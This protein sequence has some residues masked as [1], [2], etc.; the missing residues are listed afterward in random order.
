MN[1]NQYIKIIKVKGN[2]K[3]VIPKEVRDK[4]DIKFCDDIIIL[5]NKKQ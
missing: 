5:C 2:K 1:K 4:I 3:K